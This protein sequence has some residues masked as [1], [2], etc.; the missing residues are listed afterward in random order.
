MRED[1]YAIYKNAIK[2]YKN[3]NFCDIK[4][5]G[6]IDISLQIKHIL[7]DLRST[8]DYIAI[9]IYSKYNK[10]TKSKIYFPYV[11]EGK[12][13]EVFDKYFNSNLP[14]VKE[15][16]IKIYEIIKN[17]QPFT[18]KLWLSELM[19]LTN[20]IK[21]V[22]LKINKI[23]IEKH[24]TATDGKTGVTVIGDTSIEKIAD[25]QYGVFGEGQ[26]FVS[27]EGSI[28]FYPGGIIKVGEGSYNIDNK[29]KNNLKVKQSFVNKLFF[30]QYDNIESE[31]IMNNIIE[32]I[33]KIIQDIENILK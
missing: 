16:N 21:H 8:L 30:T 13:E 19:I 6:L 9:D 28:S 14:N 17:I 10:K 29:T 22:E 3:V 20:N 23:Y 25:E 4:E 11:K 31:Q 7:E 24:T 15:N 33:G 32:G 5:E 2:Q 12:T 1:I 27:G 18:G 26:V